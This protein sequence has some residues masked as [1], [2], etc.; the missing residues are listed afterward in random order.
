MREKKSA[1]A[2]G[3]DEQ[4][5][6]LCLQHTLK[7]TDDKRGASPKDSESELLKAWHRS[8]WVLCF[9]PCKVQATN[10]NQ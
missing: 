7:N 2:P 5:K 4:T 8:W 1:R 9:A 3:K 10:I 6:Y